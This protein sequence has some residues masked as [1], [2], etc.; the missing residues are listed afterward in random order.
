MKTPALSFLRPLLIA[1]F[2]CALVVSIGGCELDDND[3]NNR[4]R[5][6]FTNTNPTSATVNFDGTEFTPDLVTIAPNGVV[7]FNNNADADMQIAFEMD[8]GLSDL[9][10]VPPGQ[11]AQQTFNTAGSYPFRE[12]FVGNAGGTIV[13][14]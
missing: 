8:S 3:N 1:L 10:P 9:G 13:V 7:T 6:T 5:D 12:L 11:S 2:A 14:E 4:P